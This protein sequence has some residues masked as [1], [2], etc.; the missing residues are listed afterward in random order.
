MSDS[1]KENEKKEELSSVP[2][3]EL[4]VSGISKHPSVCSRI[5][6]VFNSKLNKGKKGLHHS[7][8]ILMSTQE[9]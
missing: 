1:L 5:T 9:E 2:F 7:Q 6:L 4:T 8:E 3:H